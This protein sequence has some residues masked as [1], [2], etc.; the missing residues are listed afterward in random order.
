MLRDICT[1]IINNKNLFMLLTAGLY[2][3]ALF[4]VFSGSV[5]I[6]SF[7]ITVLFV[8]LLIKNLFPIRYVL[9]WVAIFYLGIINTSIRLNFS[10]ELLNLAT[11]NCE[12]T[13][14]VISIPQGKSE[15]KPKFFFKVDKIF[16]D[17][18]RKKALMQKDKARS[19]RNTKWQASREKKTN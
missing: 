3:L 4:S 14:S 9:I 11:R 1:A 18:T 6:F 12:I 19:E 16:F 7:I 15:N 8:F 10:N 2:I 5:I 17:T 13:G